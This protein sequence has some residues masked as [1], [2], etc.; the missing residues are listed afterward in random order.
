MRST[1]ANRNSARLI[2]K[3]QML[4]R[5]FCIKV[6]GKDLI[7]FPPAMIG[8]VVKLFFGQKDIPSLFYRGQ[9]AQAGLDSIPSA[10]ACMAFSLE[11]PMVVTK[12][13]SGSWR[14][15]SSMLNSSSRL[16]F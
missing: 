9:P 7:T 15:I 6:V 1:A 11:A 12:I 13:K 3:I 16:P 5:F 2:S 8:L 4:C 10:S 14:M